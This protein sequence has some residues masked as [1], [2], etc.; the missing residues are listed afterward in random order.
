MSHEEEKNFL[1]QGLGAK[2]RELRG[3]A[4]LTIKELAGRAGLSLRFVNQLEAGQGNISVA[5]LARVA[6]ALGRPLAD[7]LP[8]KNHDQSLRARLWQLVTSSSD[9]ELQELQ[10]WFEQRKG[11]SH[12]HFIALIG[13]RGAG[14]STVGVRLAK[15]LK[16][17]FVELDARVEQ[18]AGMSL[19][20]IFSMHGEEYYRRL[21]QKALLKLFNESS[22][23]VLATGGSLVTAT[24]SWSLVK[25]HCFT[26]W[27]QAKPEDHMNRVLRQ[28]DLRPMKDNPAAMNEL[29]AL[30]ARRN[31][32][33]AE[34]AIT[35]KTST[36]TPTA[37]VEQIAKALPWRNDRKT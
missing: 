16:T 21:E 6:S 25:R 9:A 3:A 37:I 29:K 2:V 13:L 33:Y 5:G 15:K 32:L 11:Q 10:R 14:K 31:P 23:C 7:L 1:L 24:E 19:R 8:P 36:R 26:V 27:L 4:N 35:V 20:E 12:R 18:A 28:G 17:E 22:G 30:L 34:A